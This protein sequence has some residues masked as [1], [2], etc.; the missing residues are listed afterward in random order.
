MYSE[1]KVGAIHTSRVADGGSGT[2][3]AFSCSFFATNS[4]VA[5]IF[6]GMGTASDELMNPVY[7][8]TDFPTGNDRAL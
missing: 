3:A 8:G 2:L 4:G 1:R 6:T 7:P 5:W